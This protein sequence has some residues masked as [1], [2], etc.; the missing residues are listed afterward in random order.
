MSHCHLNYHYHITVLQI[1]SSHLNL[2]D[3]YIIVLPISR[4]IEKLTVATLGSGSSGQSITSIYNTLKIL[5][6]LNSEVKSDLHRC[7][8]FGSGRLCTGLTF[9][10]VSM[11]CFFF[12]AFIYIFFS[13]SLFDLHAH[14]LE[15]QDD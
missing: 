6:C 12:L 11:Y 9:V 7:N 10:T 14:W 4:R 15:V 3:Y 1:M 2:V 5:K 8:Y 13:L